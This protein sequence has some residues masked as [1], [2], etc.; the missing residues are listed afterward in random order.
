M[1]RVNDRLALDD[2]E[3]VTAQLRHHLQ[4]LIVDLYADAPVTVER[5]DGGLDGRLA[6]SISTAAAPDVATLLQRL[7]AGDRYLAAA[8]NGHL[9]GSG[10]AR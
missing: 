8:A 10:A 2:A 6:L 7:D 9:A 5:H 4:S 3:Q 1:V